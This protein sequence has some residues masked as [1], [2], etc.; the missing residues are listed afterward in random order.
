M[1]L[2]TGL[3][4]SGRGGQALHLIELYVGV[5]WVV[6][7]TRLASSDGL[8]DLLLGPFSPSATKRTSKRDVVRVTLPYDIWALTAHKG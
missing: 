6:T 1:N 2:L 5:G 8:L 4:P 7:T 3:T